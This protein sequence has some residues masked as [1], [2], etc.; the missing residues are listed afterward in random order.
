MIPTKGRVLAKPLI[1]PT[2][3]IHWPVKC[4][5]MKTT[6]TTGNRLRM[7]KGAVNQ[8]TKKVERLAY[9]KNGKVN[10]HRGATKSI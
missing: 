7:N 5:V 2:S 6:A 1:K 8:S 4:S 3:A 9:N 10:L